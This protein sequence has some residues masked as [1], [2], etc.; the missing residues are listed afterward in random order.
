M[1]A[2]YAFWKTND[3]AP[4]IQ[5][6]LCGGFEGASA[7]PPPIFARHCAHRREKL[8]HRARNFP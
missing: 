6:T 8:R 5:V 1:I 3:A 2:L 4:G 7:L